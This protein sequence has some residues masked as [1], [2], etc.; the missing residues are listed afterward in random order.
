MSANR[1]ERATGEKEVVIGLAVR[2]CKAGE[3]L[4]AFLHAGPAIGRLQ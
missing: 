3:P 1:I 4:V 2:A